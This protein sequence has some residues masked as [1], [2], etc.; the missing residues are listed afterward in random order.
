M[1]SFL[2][3]ALAAGATLAPTAPANAAQGCGPGGHRG[4]YGHCR[5]NGYGR[6]MGQTWVVG[7]FY[8]GRGYWDGRRWYQHRD[9]WHGG[10]R[11]R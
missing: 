5:P 7:N 1:K 10:W 9:R 3:L 8:P 2:A 6:P 11:Y 4:P